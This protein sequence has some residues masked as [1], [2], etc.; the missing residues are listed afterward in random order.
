MLAPSA[1]ML[2][3]MAP[4]KAAPRRNRSYF[5]PEK[6]RA[7]YMAGQGKNAGEIALEL[8]GT[9]PRKIRDMLRDCGIKLVRPFGRP[10]AVR[11]HCTNTDLRRLDEEAAAREVDPGDLALHMLRVLL[12]EP[13]LLR[14]LL[15]EVDG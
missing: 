13:T 11:I 4:E 10:K 9:T 6:M 14:N 1:G 15:D 3:T 2:T 5:G 12:A 7:A 8:G